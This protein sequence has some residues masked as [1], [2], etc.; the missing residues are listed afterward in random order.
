MAEVQ[1][2]NRNWTNF[3]WLTYHFDTVDDYVEQMTKAYS[4]YD[5]SVPIDPKLT[6]VSQ[7][8]RMLETQKV[9]L[10]QYYTSHSIV[11]QTIA[12]LNRLNQ[13][14][15]SIF[16]INNMINYEYGQKSSRINKFD[17]FSKIKRKIAEISG[18][19]VIERANQVSIDK[20]EFFKVS[21]EAE[22]LAHELLINKVLSSLKTKMK[23]EKY[24]VESLEQKS[25][26]KFFLNGEISKDLYPVII[27]NPSLHS[28]AQVINITIDAPFAAVFDEKLQPIDSEILNM[29]T[30][31]YKNDQADV[32]QSADTKFLYFETA[33]KPLETKIYFVRHIFN[34]SDCVGSNEKYCASQTHQ[35]DISFSDNV[36]IK[37]NKVKVTLN[38][39]FLPKTITN[40]TSDESVE[41]IV[42]LYEYQES[43][44]LSEDKVLATQAKLRFLEAVK[45][46]GE[47]ITQIH[48]FGSNGPMTKDG[49]L[50]EFI[51]S[52]KKNDIYPILTTKLRTK[53]NNEIVLRIEV[54]KIDYKL[55]KIFVSD[56]IFFK[57]RELKKNEIVP[58]VQGITQTFKN[59]I[60]LTLNDHT[61]ACRQ[62][63]RAFEYIL[64]NS[65]DNYQ[66]A[67][68][69]TNDMFK[70]YATAHFKIGL[71][72]KERLLYDIQ[73]SNLI[74]AKVILPELKL[75]EFLNEHATFV[76]F[77]KP[78][79]FPSNIEL[80][81]L[82][83]KSNG[84]SY[85]KLRNR[86]EQET[87][88]LSHPFTSQAYKIQ[89]DK[90]F[91]LNSLESKEEF[92][93]FHKQS[94]PKTTMVQ[95][96]R[97]KISEHRKLEALINIQKSP[98]DIKFAKNLEKETEKIKLEGE[99]FVSYLIQ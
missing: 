67:Y 1:K 11:K 68:R 9:D 54:P 44:N 32:S 86:M 83:L 30:F 39:S 55:S 46:E 90:K 72:P 37:N 16:V 82:E 12:D 97:S 14:L 63:G 8:K 3:K 76:D 94:Y 27:F 18:H 87:E 28:S 6:I 75:Q 99:E 19:D 45:Q 50:V 42:E 64:Q 20:N 96:L 84:N 85:I 58:A 13:A 89:S 80:V 57:E 53:S 29:N 21:K 91:L 17:D 41:M 2:L 33:L 48:F 56:S 15:S 47:L 38:R 10:P 4:D 81:G 22:T 77:I 51:I 74:T 43:P 73:E 98:I 93:D 40:L 61:I 66:L 62:F 52:L 35:S 49:D 92:L 78:D 34:E 70:E 60:F 31:T 24:S 26:L 23:N 59:K 95:D 88:I 25:H 71:T 36:L 7:T 5:W 65:A 69:D 79:S